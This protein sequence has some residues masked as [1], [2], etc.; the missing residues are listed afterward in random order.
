MAEAVDTGRLIVFEGPDGVGK[1]TL[2]LAL[3]N[4]LAAIGLSCEHLSFPGKEE[5]TL[6][7]LVYNVH[8]RPAEYGIGAITAASLQALHIAAHLDTIERRIIPALNEGCWVILDRFWWS[9]WAYGH[10]DAVDRA[11]LDAMV[12]VER[13]HWCGVEPDALFLLDRHNG[14]FDG[15]GRMQLRKSYDLLYENERSRYPI[16][17]IQNDLPVDRSVDRLIAAIRDFVPSAANLDSPN[18]RSSARQESG[19]LSLPSMDEWAPTILTKLVSARPTVVYGSYWQFAAE[20]QEVFFRKIGGFA[21]PWTN[22]PIIARHKFT[23][24]YRASDRVSQFLIKNVIYE[25]DQSPT[26]CSSARFFSSS[27]TRSRPGRCCRIE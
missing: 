8:H 6:G 12:Q 21:A 23:N 4:R 17:R 18:R 25:G 2:A 10:V 15:D 1:S 11:T 20:R 9:T 16:H 5:G 19:Q 3:T 22:D 27:S 24:A 26:R 14:S 7:S 13:L